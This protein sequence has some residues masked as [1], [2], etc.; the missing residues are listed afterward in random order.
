MQFL[1]HGVVGL[2]PNLTS[3]YRTSVCFNHTLF[4]LRN[5]VAAEL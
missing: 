1:T 2:E 4:F 3:Y 5:E